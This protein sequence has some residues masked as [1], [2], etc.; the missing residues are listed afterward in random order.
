M[1]RR[2]SCPVAVGNTDMNEGKSTGR[3]ADIYLKY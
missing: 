3:L 2:R 1:R